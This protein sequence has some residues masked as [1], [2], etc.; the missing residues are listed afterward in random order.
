MKHL[1]IPKIDLICMI[2]GRTDLRIGLSGAKFREQSDFEVRLAIAPQKPDQN[3]EKLI[4]LIRKIRRKFF[5]R[6]R[7][8]KCRG[9][10]ETRFGKVSRRSEPS[11][12]SKWPFKVCRAPPLSC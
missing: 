7:K 12:R 10:S 3:G 11:L 1:V 2:F 8:M 4:F 5:C 6:R 9:S